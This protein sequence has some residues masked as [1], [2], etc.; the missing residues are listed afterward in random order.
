M[1]ESPQRVAE[2]VD[3]AVAA[4]PGVAR[5]YRAVPTAAGRAAPSSVLAHVT[6]L[7]RRVAVSVGVTEADDSRVVAASVA[8]AVRAVL[9]EDW[10]DAAVRVQ[11]RRIEQLD[12]PPEG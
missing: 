5:A 11:V 1:P 10:S 12:P 4:L 6:L 2:L 3:A 7:P 8:G 9:P